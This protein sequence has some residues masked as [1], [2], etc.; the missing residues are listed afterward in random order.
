MKPTDDKTNLLF[1][2]FS[3][4][5]DSVQ[6]RMLTLID[7]TNR[8]LRSSLRD[9][10]DHKLGFY[11]NR[12]FTNGRKESVRREIDSLGRSGRAQGPPATGASVS[13]SDATTPGVKS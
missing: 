7:F 3:S 13:G 5:L 10:T 6:W 11:P 9:S 2:F 1:R 12:S 4:L 8:L